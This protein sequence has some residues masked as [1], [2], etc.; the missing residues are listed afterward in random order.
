MKKQSKIISLVLSVILLLGVFVIS[1]SAAL[2]AD[3][4][5]PLTPV[6]EEG[7][8]VRNYKAYTFDG[9][10]TVGGSN[11]ANTLAE[12]KDAKNYHGTVTKDG[13]KYYEMRWIGGKGYIDLPLQE[14]YS[15]YSANDVGHM[16]KYTYMV[17]SV[18]VTSYGN[19]IDENYT[20]FRF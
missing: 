14:S 1:S 15:K 10:C 17:V 18:D 4:G 12:Y 3:D 13:N 11:S 7:A 8:N 6:Y 2:I 16:S 5:N 20:S 9:T 19:Y